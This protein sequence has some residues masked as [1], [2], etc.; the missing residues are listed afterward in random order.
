MERILQM[1]LTRKPSLN[2]LEELRVAI[3]PSY[4]VSSLSDRLACLNASEKAS[5]QHLAPLIHKSAVFQE[6]I[7][8]RYKS[9]LVR[10]Q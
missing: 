6:W 1:G 7:V 8:F 3:L 9:Q 5:V 2:I 10:N 4:T